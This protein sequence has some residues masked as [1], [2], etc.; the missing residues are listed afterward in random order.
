M[1]MRTKIKKLLLLLQVLVL[2]PLFLAVGI[3]DGILVVVRLVM[4]IGAR[5]LGFKE[6][7]HLLYPE[8]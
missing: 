7:A 5:D 3:V 8:R 1:K 2:S 4:A 6:S